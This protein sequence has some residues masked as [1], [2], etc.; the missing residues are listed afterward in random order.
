MKKLKKIPLS[1]LQKSDVRDLLE[2][3]TSVL[4][5]CN[6][7][8]LRLEYIY[9]VL[10][11]QEVKVQK[12][13]VPYGPHPLTYKMTRLHKKRLQYATLIHMQIRSLEKVDCDETQRMAKLAMKLSKEYLTYLGQKRTSTVTSR[14][15]LFFK[16]LESTPACQDAYSGLGLQPFLDELKKT[17]TAYQEVSY[18]RTDEI[19]KRP[20]TGDR[21]LE[22]ETQKMLRQ[23]FE[24]VISYQRTFADIDYTQLI[25]L[26]NVELTKNSKT[27]KTRI[28][29]NKR[30]ARK[31]A[32]AAKEA[33]EKEMQTQTLIETTAEI[34][35]AAISETLQEAS[36]ESIPLVGSS[37]AVKTNSS[38]KNNQIGKIK[39]ATKKEARNAKKSR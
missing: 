33:A 16:N 36:V 34:E 22:R 25:A 3:V 15:F 26:L 13:T 11:Q 9:E 5:N 30:R 21:P 35:I 8:A 7:E 31:K 32:L 29:T 12:L 6:P 4:E 2:Q 37:V 23:F 39:R 17:S 28:A 19:E 14:I 20:T 18:Q 38:V 24:Q 1:K 27:I 10:K